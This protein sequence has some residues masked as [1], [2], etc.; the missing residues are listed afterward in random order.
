[1]EARTPSESKTILTDLVLPSE[2]NPFKQSF[3]RRIISK[4]G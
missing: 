2:T 4:D 1:M 3:W